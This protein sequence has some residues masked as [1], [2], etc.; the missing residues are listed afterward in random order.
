MKVAY[1]RVSTKHQTPARQIDALKNK[2]DELHIE[3][4]SANAKHRPVFT[5]VLRKLRSGDTLLIQDID[6]AFR[7]TLD[8][9]TIMYRLHDRGI[10]LEILSLGAN[11]ITP[12]GELLYTM[13]A[14]Y[15]RYEWR[16]L[17]RRT[18]QGMMAAKKRGKH[19]GRPRKNPTGQLSFIGF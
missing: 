18:K 11:T 6:R 9:L 19:I 8:A 2:S 3:Q 17:S 5:K 4:L 16:C 15:S 13:T 1:L 10:A 7:N 14:A 12:E